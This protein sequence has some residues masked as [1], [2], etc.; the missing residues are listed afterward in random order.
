MVAEDV[1]GG[2][3]SAAVK[4]RRSLS[5]DIHSNFPQLPH[6]KAAMSNG[7]HVQSSFVRHERIGPDRIIAPNPSA[8]D[9]KS[10][11]EFVWRN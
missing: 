2:N 9:E 7:G 8:S 1:C 6:V 10:G 11:Q 4:F 3:I 5:G